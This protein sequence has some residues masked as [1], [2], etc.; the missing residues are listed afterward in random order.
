MKNIPNLQLFLTLLLIS[1]FLFILDSLGALKYPKIALSFITTPIQ[2][3]FYKSF[4]NL[5]QQ[6]YFIKNAKDLSGQNENLKA[7][8][9][10]A[11][12]ENATLQ[13]KLS[14]AND[15]ISQS[16]YLDPKNYNLLPARPIG[17]DRNLHIDKG[18]E[19]GVQT[20]QVVVFENNF[21]GKVA[22]VSPKGASITLITDPY[23]KL[24]A[25]SQNLEGKAKGIILGQ[26]GA[27]L[28]FDKILQEEKI[29]EGNLVFSD[30]LEEFIPRGLILGKVST[31]LG[32][33]SEVFKQAKV[34]PTFDVRDLEVVFVILD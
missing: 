7:Q 1:S 25:F 22:H 11:L 32:K 8:L 26:F 17:L 15:Q 21:I 3:G 29:K 14:E 9:G 13:R 30:G 10:Q 12:S 5:G 4:Q 34:K 18:S 28:I 24:S 31:V 20:G 2:Y 27:E 6:F 16:N 33:S 23:T 19:D